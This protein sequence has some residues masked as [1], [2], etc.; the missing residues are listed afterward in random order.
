G[1]SRHGHVCHQ[2]LLPARRSTVDRTDPLMAARRAPD[3]TTGWLAVAHP[4]TPTHLIHA[5]CEALS[6]PAPVP[7]PVPAPPGTTITHP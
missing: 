1:L 4:N 7:R 2:V 6:D 3:T 5:L